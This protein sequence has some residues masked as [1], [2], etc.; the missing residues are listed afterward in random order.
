MNNISYYNANPIEVDQKSSSLLWSEIESNSWAVVIPTQTPGRSGNQI[1]LSTTGNHNLVIGEPI[2]ISAVQPDTYRNNGQDLWVS[3]IPSGTSFTYQNRLADTTS[4][5]T[6]GTVVGT[7]QYSSIPDYYRINS[8]NIKNI[9]KIYLG[10]YK[11]V[12]DT[13]TDSQKLMF[14]KYQYSAYTDVKVNTIILD[15]L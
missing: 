10:T 14:N 1:T 12:I 6:A 15:I 5:T 4:I 8:N 9:Y 7:W 13:D 2:T 11:N 3:D